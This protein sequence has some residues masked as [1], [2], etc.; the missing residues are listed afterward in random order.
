M[1][2]ITELHAPR[3]PGLLDTGLFPGFCLIVVTVSWARGTL[4]QAL[5]RAVLRDLARTQPRGVDGRFEGR[6]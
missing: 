1:L 4:G 2:V 3:W 5:K 6:R